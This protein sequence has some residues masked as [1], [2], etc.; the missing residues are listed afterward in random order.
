MTH[1]PPRRLAILDPTPAYRTGLHSC[2]ADSGYRLDQPK[3]PLRWAQY[4]GARVALVTL[5]TPHDETLI[6]DLRRTRTDLA[7]ITLIPDPTLDDYLRAIRL[8]ATTAMPW[9]AEP[10]RLLTLVQALEHGDIQLPIEI[11]HQLASAAALQPERPAWVTQR[12]IELLRALADGTTVQQ[13]AL[14]LNRSERTIYRMLAELY[15][16]IGATNR[17]EAAHWANRHNLLHQ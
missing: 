11:L 15:R 3:D 5:R 6:T 4:P 7:I 14:D 12:D 17:Y 10:T 1:R 13:L 9:N 2:L 16:R 8:G